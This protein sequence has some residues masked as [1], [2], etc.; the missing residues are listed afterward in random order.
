M[1]RPVTSG[2]SRS[3]GIAVEAR[4]ITRLLLGAG[5]L[6][7]AAVVFWCYLREAAAV[8]VNSD[9]ASI[10]LQ[11]W[12][13]LHGNLLL[14]GWSL[15]DVSFYTT[16]LPEYMLVGAV[17]GLSPGT[18]H[19]CAAITYMLIVLLV[20]LLAK[21]AAT[22]RAAVVRMAIAAGIVLAPQDNAF[23]VL[24][25]SPDHTGTS[26][27][28]LAALLVLD[29]GG[30]RR[31]VP[32]AVGAL[33]IWGLIADE[34]VIVAGVLPV[35]A[36]CLLRAVR[37]LRAGNERVGTERAGWRF[38]LW[39]GTAAIAAVPASALIT[40]A[41]TAAG[42]WRLSQ[43]VRSFLPAS[44]MPR[45]FWQT[46]EGVLRLFGADFFGRPFGL[47]AVF[48]AV[49]LAGAALVVVAVWRTLRG[50]L[51]RG[52]LLPAVLAVG[53]VANVVAY[54]T[55]FHA[56]GSAVR[57][58]VPVMALGAALA[59]RVLAGPLIRARL[60]PV[61]A[62]GLAGYLIMLGAGATHRALPPNQTA[63][64]GW[65]MS[66]K[67][68]NGIAAY[69]QAPEVTLDSGG[70]VHLATVTGNTHG[71]IVRSHWE[72]SSD[73]F[74]PRKH[75]A[76]FL[77]TGTQGVTEYAAAATFGRPARVLR[78]KHY[79]VMVW[80]KNLLTALAAVP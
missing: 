64:T 40:H 53:I 42:G 44:D 8:S 76:D 24:L 71:K 7:T 5:L 36:V 37:G 25:M 12:D 62:A 50:G 46:I 48:A 49:H 55:L 30:R 16:E 61:L 66:H 18:V 67:L 45:N 56:G 39:L 3:V 63:L 68:T 77:V 10:T 23:V 70:K 54:M 34:L 4:S 29:R 20:A 52:D 31:W 69:W 33:L 14:H 22:G 75:H 60:E 65:L 73:W 57:E 6:V 1:L 58:I 11:A 21:G 32:A 27:P 19:V 79:T 35:F 28:L 13:M 38:E 80:R 26:V 17:R 47:N 2:A 41:I 78:F 74:D 9:G 59:G 15:S 51:L 43:G 72:T